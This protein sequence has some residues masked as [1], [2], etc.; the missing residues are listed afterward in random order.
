MSQDKNNGGVKRN[1]EGKL[2][3]GKMDGIAQ[4]GKPAGGPQETRMVGA[5]RR[6]RQRRCGEEGASGCGWENIAARAHRCGT[7]S[8]FD[9]PARAGC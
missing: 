1:S 7:M 8:W 4:Q 5:S 3:G 9:A 2:V 6:T